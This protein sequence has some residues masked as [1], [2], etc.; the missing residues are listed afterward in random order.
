MALNAALV[1]IAD[2]LTLAAT[3]HTTPVAT[4]E[5]GHGAFVRGIGSGSE[6]T[7]ATKRVKL[8]VDRPG[9][10]GTIGVYGVNL[11][12]A[13]SGKPQGNAFATPQTETVKVFQ[14]AAQAAS[15]TQTLDASDLSA[16]TPANG[17]ATVTAGVPTNL[18]VVVLNGEILDYSATPA[19][20]KVTFTVAAGVITLRT[21]TGITIA[22][23]ADVAA[24]FVAAPTAIMAVGAHA[25]ENVGILS[26][27]LV[28]VTTN[29]A[30]TAGRTLVTLEHLAE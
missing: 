24:Y 1:L 22:S 25:V 15:S 16:T 30:I 21:G 4:G 12:D 11:P 14:A 13:L 2:L 6:R 10:D 29:A 9:A 23:G 27:D 28:F 19:A 20:G 26:T 17:A 7:R 5:K 18:W 8:R 3:S